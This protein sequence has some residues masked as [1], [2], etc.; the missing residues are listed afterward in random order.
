MEESRAI[1]DL[2]VLLPNSHVD[3]W[4]EGRVGF[5]NRLNVGLKNRKPILAIGSEVR[6]TGSH[7]L[8]L[9]RQTLMIRC[10]CLQL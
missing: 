4:V 8:V 1:Q 2:A 3:H 5:G 9:I 7:L 10:Y 6:S